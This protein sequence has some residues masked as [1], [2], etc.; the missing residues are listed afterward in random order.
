VVRWLSFVALS[1][2]AGNALARPARPEAPR[3]ARADDRGGDFWRE[4]IEP[5]AETVTAILAKARAAIDKLDA[6]DADWA[7]E[8]RMRSLG[9]VYG[10]LR[11]AHK[12]SPD[13]TDVLALLGFTADETGQTRQALDALE[14]CVRLHSPERAGVE[15]TGRLGM[16]YLRLG[17]LDDAIRW[18][19]YAQ[20]PLTG[21]DN[22]I[23]VVHLA[24][25]L[26]ARGQ[27]P[28]AIDV[29]VNALPAQTNYFTDPVTLVAFALAVHYDRDEQRGAAFDILDRMQATLQAEIG[30]FAQR[31]L[32]TM[33]FAPAEDQYYY[34]ALLYEMLGDYTEARAEWALYAAIPDGP[35]RRRALEHIAAIDTQRARPGAAPRG[36]QRSPRKVS[37]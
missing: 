37:P 21:P 5:H 3:P 10:M 2:A 23:A 24:T 35:W 17:Q 16:I 18:L 7:V 33:R 25:A 8:R 11:Y 1:F 29:L 30:P 4:V 26:A 36:A 32:A 22:A 14:S 12:L 9:D 20:G 34:Q 28:D 13:N 6:G 27:M 31:A 15:V 19:R